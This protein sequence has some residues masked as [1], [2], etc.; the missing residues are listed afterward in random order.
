MCNG[1]KLFG[2][3][4]ADLAAV[5]PRFGELSPVL[6]PRDTEDGNSF[7]CRTEVRILIPCCSNQVSRSS[8]PGQNLDLCLK[9]SLND[10]SKCIISMVT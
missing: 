9:I 2:N 3:A 4:N 10:T 1:G 7:T 5:I 8:E 6:E